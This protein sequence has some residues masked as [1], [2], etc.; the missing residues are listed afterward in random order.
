MFCLF[1]ILSFSYG[2]LQL[3]DQDLRAGIASMYAR[4]Q[5]D[6]NRARIQHP[7]M[8]ELGLALK[9]ADSDILKRWAGAEFYPELRE[10]GLR[11]LE[12]YR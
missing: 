5:V 7:L 10:Q 6:Y 3:L 9:M 11:E 4:E 1:V 12:S 8:R 2:L